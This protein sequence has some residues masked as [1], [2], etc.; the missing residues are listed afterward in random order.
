M[1]KNVSQYRGAGIL[2]A[3]KLSVIVGVMLRGYNHRCLKM[4]IDYL[5]DERVG[6]N[7]R[8]K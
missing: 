1:C 6:K 2:K 8:E 4:M 5:G 3:D 7:G